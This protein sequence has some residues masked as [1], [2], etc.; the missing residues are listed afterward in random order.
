MADQNGA[1]SSGSRLNPFSRRDEFS[2]R[3]L[4]LHRITTLVTYIIFVI[5]AIYYTF[6][7]PHEGHHPW[8]TIWGNN[9]ATPFAQNK[10]MTS[11]YWIVLLLLQLVYAWSLYSKDLVYVN[12]AANIGSHYIASNLLLFGF[13]HLWVRSHFWLAEL[14]IIINFF[15]LSFAYFRHSTT[16]R[17][18]H[19]G[20]VAGPLA[21]NFVALYWVGARAVP[22]TDALPARIVG[23]IFIWGILAYGS[24]FLVAFKDYTM[25]F[26]LS[27][28]AFSTG[29]GQFM[30][31]I[32]IFQLQW[33]F[34]F[35]IGA[36][37]FILS[38]GVSSGRT[39]FD[40]G[41]VVSE[42]RERAPLLR[43]GPDVP[44]EARE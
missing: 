44:R 31:K 6:S 35:T 14:L 28:L 37:L 25:G 15:N 41:E 11:I 13:L 24:F 29:V 23:N 40:G 42:D 3:E 8:H 4:I 43:D 38:L 12:A 26:A 7:A 34:A 17:P 18:I 16:P 32:P 22:H 33:I 1:A 21:W 19:I 30:T 39:P 27:Y 5:T 2:S 9:A 20:T 10:V 36:L